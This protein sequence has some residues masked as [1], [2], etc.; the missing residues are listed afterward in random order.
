MKKILIIDD[1]NELC[2][3][4]TTYLDAEGFEV[5][6]VQDST[7]GLSRALSGDHELVILDVMLPGIN[8]FELLSKLRGH[9]EVPVMML[10]ARGDEVD[11]IV[12]LEMGADD[13]LPKPFNPRELVARL[14]AIRRRMVRP[15][16]S[17]FNTDG[18]L[19]AIS[20]G[21]LILEPKTKSLTRDG[22][23]IVVTAAE[24]DLL[25]ELV[26]KAGNTV[27]REDLTRKV[28]GR[29]PSLFDRSV[30]VHVASLRKKLGHRVNGKE[31]IKAV[32]GVGYIYTAM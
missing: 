12:G 31:R 9:S 13:Y 32:R 14:R 29:K 27:S 20:V 24:F 4:L 7:T 2:Q 28:L 19:S 8:G 11:R 6:A 5:E 21:D 17:P 15:V 23:A 16:E 18:V 26:C 25:Y 1:D 3:L 30:D 22:Q 10:T